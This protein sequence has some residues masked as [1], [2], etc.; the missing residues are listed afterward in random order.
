MENLCAEFWIALRDDW[1]MKMKNENALLHGDVQDIH[2]SF[3]CALLPPHSM[4]TPPPLRHKLA[5]SAALFL[6]LKVLFV[7][8]IIFYINITY[9]MK[10]CEGISHNV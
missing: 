2:V 3:C 6:D 5:S 8:Y 9:L 7:Y 4:T 10:S 1:T